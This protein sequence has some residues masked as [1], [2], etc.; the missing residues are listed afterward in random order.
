MRRYRRTR[1]K[2]KKQKNWSG[3]KSCVIVTEQ[4]N[5]NI[6]TYFDSFKLYAKCRVLRFNLDLTHLFPNQQYATLRMYCTSITLYAFA[7]DDDKIRAFLTGYGG[8]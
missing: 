5:K 8:G 3:N 6:Y 4:E 2:K 1:R 7:E